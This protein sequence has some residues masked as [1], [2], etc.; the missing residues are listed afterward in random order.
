MATKSAS[1]K[2]PQSARRKPT[3]KAASRGVP[4]VRIIIR[5]GL[6]L[7]PGKVDLIEAIG[8]SGSISAA[9]RDMGMSYRRAW[10]LVDALNHMFAEPVVV[11][12]SGGNRGG[13]AAVTEFGKGVAAAYRRIEE[14]TRKA[15]S[16]ELAGVIDLAARAP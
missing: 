15:I 9:A 2:Q 1:D 11:A 4:R 7:G 14:R 13:G 16:E 12:A 6:I 10:L 3:G 8:R 5:E